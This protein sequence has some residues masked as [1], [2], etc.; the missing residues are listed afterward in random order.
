MKEELRGIRSKLGSEHQNVALHPVK[1]PIGQWFQ[2]YFKSPFT[3]VEAKLLLGECVDE[4]LKRKLLKG[5]HLCEV[6]LVVED[7]EDL[8]S[9]WKAIRLTC[10][11][12]RSVAFRSCVLDYVCSK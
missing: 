7:P 9:S 8:N 12:T 5:D 11:G 6:E 10:P 4:A 1:A 3:F 2:I